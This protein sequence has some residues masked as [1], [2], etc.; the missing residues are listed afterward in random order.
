MAHL[1]RRLDICGGSRTILR[2]AGSIWSCLG[3]LGPLQTVC[4]HQTMRAD[5]ETAVKAPTMNEQTAEY[6]E[7]T[8]EKARTTYFATSFN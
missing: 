4:L 6:A 2:C 8:E 5:A 1:D 7:N 3:A